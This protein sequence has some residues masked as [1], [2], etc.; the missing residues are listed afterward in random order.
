MATTRKKSFLLTL[1]TMLCVILHKSYRYRFFNIDNRQ[2]A[3]I[4]HAKK[5]FVIASWHQN[6]FAGILAHAGQGFA[7]LVSRSLDG[8]IVSRLA[9]AIGL[10][11]VR[12]SSK[13]GGQEALD[14]LIERTHGG[15]RSAFTVDG[16]KGPIFEIKRGVFVLAAETGAPILPMAAIG[17]RYWTLHKSWDKFRIPKPFTKVSVLYGKPIHVTA[18]ELLNNYEE[19]KARLT[20]ELVTLEIQAVNMG[21]CPHPGSLPPILDTRPRGFPQGIAS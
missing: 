19:L 9:K 4:V 7:L 12:G 2:E 3:E 8:E 13:K 17:A 5:S 1:S 10:Q 16:P 21:L 6:C 11:T 15:L 20:K 18:D 14:V